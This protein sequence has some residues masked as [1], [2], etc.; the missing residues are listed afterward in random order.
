MY[1]LH[2]PTYYY[3]CYPHPG[4]WPI[5]QLPNVDPN[6]LYQSANESKKLMK[7]ASMVLNK[8]S[9]SKEFDAELMY[10]AQASDLEEVQR[11][12]HSI[13]VTSD[14]D[15][16]YNPDGLR[17]EFRSEVANMDCCRLYIALRWR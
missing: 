4:G 9:D 6:L 14:V 10:A 5:R 12:I 15:I 2:H 3:P 1:Y 17:L 7:D 13:G 16:Q 8:L 11:L